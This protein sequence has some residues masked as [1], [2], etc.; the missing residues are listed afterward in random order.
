VLRTQEQLGYIVA[1]SQWTLPG[2]VHFGIRILVQSERHP[3]YLEERVEA[4]LGFMKSKLETM[5]E[6]EFL[7]QKTGLERKW[8]EGAKN[9]IEETNRYWAHIEP[10][11][12]DF[13]RRVYFDLITLGSFTNTYHSG[14]NDANMVKDVTKAEV[15]AL[16]L[17][18]VHQSSSQRAK[19]SVHCVSRKPQPKKLSSMALLEVDAVLE[20]HGIAPPVDWMENLPEARTVPDTLQVLKELIRD[21]A[22]AATI[23]KQLVALTEQYPDESDRHGVLPAGY[24]AIGDPKKFRDSLQVAEG[25]APLVD[26]GD[27]PVSRI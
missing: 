14:D 27:L 20:K 9:L 15:L 24:V 21:P 25:A 16:F 7:E 4:F 17:S 1:C 12:L 13:H 19:L 18:S 2:D 11:V 23:E 3:T 22:A 8:R 26:W 10:G 5:P 6:G